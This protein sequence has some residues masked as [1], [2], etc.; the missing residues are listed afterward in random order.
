VDQSDYYKDKICIVTGANAGIGYALSEE[1]LNRGAQ[2]LSCVIF[3][4]S[5]QL[6]PQHA[7]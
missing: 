5:K 3:G 4:G 7:G 2:R 6:T 1:L